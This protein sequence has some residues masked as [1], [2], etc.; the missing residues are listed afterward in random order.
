MSDAYNKLINRIKDVYRL[1]S[2]AA[3]LDWDQETM[4]PKNGVAARAEEIGLIAGLAH[5]HL[6]AD[7]TRALL[8]N[9]DGDGGFVA[10]TNLREIKRKLDRAAKIPSE[11]VREIAETTTLAKEAW[12]Q[13][14]AESNFAGFAPLLSKVVDLKRKEADLIGYETEAY[15]ALMDEF[16]PGAK[17]ADIEKLF[18]ELV[19]ASRPLLD[20][21]M[22]S[23]SKP[24]LRS[25]RGI[26]R[27]R[28]RRRC[29]GRWPRRS[30][31]TSMPG[32]RTCPCIRSARRSAGRGTCG[33][34]RGISRISCRGLYSVRYTS[35]ATRCM[36]R[37]C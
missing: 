5:Q 30:T 24:A 14:R 23:P 32:A 17:A 18:V 27:A 12:A 31:S 21:L 22:A 8:E 37:A 29:R 20:K 13:A 3:L 33:S 19:A 16:E 28:G 7:E 26:I 6:V 34:P 35:R 4:M 36:S 15:D 2:I 9:A 1:E 25:S 11:L 10:Q